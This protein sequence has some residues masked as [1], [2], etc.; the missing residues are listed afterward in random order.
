M[1]NTAEHDRNQFIV[2]T[3]LYRYHTYMYN[4][5]TWKK[6]H[7]DLQLNKH[8]IHR[9]WL[10]S[11]QANHSGK[12]NFRLPDIKV[13]KRCRSSQA[14]V[15]DI[16]VVPARPHPLWGLFASCFGGEF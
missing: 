6:V 16:S 4:M 9:K 3:V 12:I 14:N 10:V 7:K 8:R 13:N 5:T 1:R 15:R 2:M 11:F